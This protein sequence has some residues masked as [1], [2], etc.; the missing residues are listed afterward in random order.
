MAPPTPFGLVSFFFST[1]TINTIVLLALLF[2]LLKKNLIPVPWALPFHNHL[3]PSSN[4]IPSTICT[5]G[6]SQNR[7]DTCHEQVQERDPRTKY[8]LKR[9]SHPNHYKI[10]THNPHITVIRIELLLGPRDSLCFP[11]KHGVIFRWTQVFV[12]SL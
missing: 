1:P 3:F 7:E 2:V 6:F 10:C 9:N 8:P 11:S 5:D 12:Y 4:F